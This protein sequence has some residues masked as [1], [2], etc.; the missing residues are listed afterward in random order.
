MEE[1]IKKDRF[2]GRQIII[3]IVISKTCL[4]KWES[5]SSLRAW[6]NLQRPFPLDSVSSLFLFTGVKPTLVSFNCRFPVLPSLP[7]SSA[8]SVSLSKGD[9]LSFDVS[10]VKYFEKPIKPLLQWQHRYL[11]SYVPS[12]TNHNTSTMSLEYDVHVPQ[13]KRTSVGNPNIECL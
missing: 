6:K 3:P 7:S 9:L 5:S 12:E 2:K 11:A 13:L 10:T 4:Q 1:T 8:S